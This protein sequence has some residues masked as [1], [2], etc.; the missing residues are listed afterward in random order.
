MKKQL[1]ITTILGVL[2]AV[3]ILGAFFMTTNAQ[4]PRSPQGDA[5]SKISYQGYLE[6]NAQQP[7]D[8]SVDMTF[9][10]YATS[11]G[12]SPVWQETQNNVT[13]SDGYFSVHLGIVNPL[14][15]DDFNSASRYIEVSVNTGGGA[16][17]L[18]RQQFTAVPYAYHAEQANSVP[19]DGI[20]DVPAGLGSEVANRIIVA[21][22]GG[23][24]TSVAAALASITDAAED[25][26][27]LV[28]VMPGEY[29]ETSLVEVK[30]YVH[31]QGS[32]PNA[33]IIRSTRTNTT[34]NNLAASVELMD[35]GRISDVTVRNE[36]TGN[37]GIALYSTQTSR[38][39]HVDNVVAE[40]IGSGGTGH[41][42]A[43]WNDA[44]ATIRNST[45][46][47]SGASGF[48]TAVNAAFGSVNI[49]SGFPQALIENSHL[50]GGAASSKENC[51]DP[52][53]TGYGLMLSNSSPM[54]RN[55]YVCGG[56]RGVAL[57]TNGHAQFQRSSIKTSS[58]GSAF[59]FE[60]SAS[61]SI[62]VANSGVS[63]IGNK[64][65]GAG[66]SGL[67][68]VDAY[69]LGT[70]ASLTDAVNSSTTACN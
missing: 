10:L 8:G 59:L 69:D 13:V 36:G 41:F 7:I 53:G 57:L 38:D 33:T 35:N 60:I 64:F 12:G 16:E 30:S 21:K 27:Y 31:L 43:Y 52:T 18:P 42:A 24:Y 51:N 39:A 37:Y 14:D 23:D 50:L 29:T 1:H 66:S 48:G 17:T 15:A 32:G 19:W 26:A 70:Y 5:P 45:L 3:L 54:I 22:S 62:K 2:T 49:A 4:L 65:T 9:A 28:Q 11:S 34:Q 68:C 25:N 20:T 40:A 6:D 67:S 61:G 55:S 47:A 56:H 63:Y 46:F 58:T 44:E